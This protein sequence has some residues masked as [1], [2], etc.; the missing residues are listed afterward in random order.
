MQTKWFCL[1]K[2][3]N[4]DFKSFC[5]LG[6]TN[7][8]LSVW[9]QLNSFT[10]ISNPGALNHYA[11]SACEP[12]WLKSVVKFSFQKVIFGEVHL[13]VGTPKPCKTL[14]FKYLLVYKKN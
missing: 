6:K 14:S 5:G 2:Q 3:I 12:N 8:R 7:V 10:T 9:T 11:S 4:V 13:G 1:M